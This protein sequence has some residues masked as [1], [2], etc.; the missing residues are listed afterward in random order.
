MADEHAE[1]G[2]SYSDVHIFKEGEIVS[3]LAKPDAVIAVTD[4]L[5]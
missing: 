5:P 2:F 3:P 4:L 1:Y